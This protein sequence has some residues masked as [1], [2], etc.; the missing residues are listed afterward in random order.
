L[1]LDLIVVVDVG[2]S[3]AKLGAVKGENVAG[4]MRLPR[5]DAR[6]VREVA[7]PMLQGR[8]AVIAL[9]GSDPKTIDGLAW[10]LEKL[11]LGTLV[12]VGP[13][14]R[15]LPEARVDHPAQVGVDRRVQ[16]LGAATLCGGPVVV[17]SCGTAIT[18]DV[19]DED[20][21][22]LGG[23][24]LPGLGLGAHALAQG[25]ARLPEV[26]LDGPVGMPARDTET[27]IRTGLRLGAAGAIDRLL[28]EADPEETRA[29]L[30]T[31]QDAKHVEGLLARP[32]RVTAGLGILGAALAVRAHPPA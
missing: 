21:V 7:A 25:T 8:E 23:A 4:P 5:A 3:G 29:V 13:K 31:G 14:F 15:G 19:A 24:I 17:V 11:R 18:V 27:A 2:N 30:L 12:K 16:V 6:A 9:T 28:A 32:A 20:G 22:L 26:E 10:E 1:D